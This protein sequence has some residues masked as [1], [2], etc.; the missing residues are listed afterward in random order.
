MR[1][2]DVTRDVADGAWRDTPPNLW[3]VTRGSARGPSTARLVAEMAYLWKLGRRDLL[4]G[5]CAGLEE[6]FDA[7]HDQV[8]IADLIDRLK[9]LEKENANG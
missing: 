1:D 8:P 4:R 7:G 9:E 5:L 2:T 3:G 6:L